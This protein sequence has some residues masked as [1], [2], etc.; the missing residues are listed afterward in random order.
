MLRILN[1][2]DTQKEKRPKSEF[3]LMFP[4]QGERQDVLYQLSVRVEYNL[5]A[6]SKTLERYAFML[7]VLK[8]VMTPYFNSLL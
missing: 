1:A 5:L 8:A 6:C 7:R 3:L 2:A 4:F